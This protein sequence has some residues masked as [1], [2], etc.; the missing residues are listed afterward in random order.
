M[1]ERVIFLTGDT[2]SQEIDVFLH[3]VSNP[4]LTKPFEMAEVKAA[5]ESLTPQAAA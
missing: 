5:L 1:A 2:L 4:C 3:S